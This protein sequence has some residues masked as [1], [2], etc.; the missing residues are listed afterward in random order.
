MR[1]QSNDKCEV[2]RTVPDAGFYYCLLTVQE[3][4]KLF[5]HPLH[6]PLTLLQE[7]LKSAS[8]LGLLIRL[9]TPFQRGYPV[10]MELGGTLSMAYHGFFW[11][12]N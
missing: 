10:F 5:T 2:L 7:G 12:E 6:R 3:E 8:S 9:A 11:R 1:F 4:G